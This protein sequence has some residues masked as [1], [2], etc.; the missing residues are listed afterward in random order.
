MCPLP[1]AHPHRW[2]PF[3]ADWRPDCGGEA[4]HVGSFLGEQ[5]GRHP[6]GGLAAVCFAQEGSCSSYF[7]SGNMIDGPSTKE[8]V[9]DLG[10]GG[11]PPQ[12][13]IKQPLKHLQLGF[14]SLTYFV[15]W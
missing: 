6:P 11:R 9:G 2:P 3:L 10:S 4:I 5:G 7:H 8:P 15:K 14:S 13:E 1:L 12:H